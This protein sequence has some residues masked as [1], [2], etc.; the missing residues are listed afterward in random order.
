[1]QSRLS[2]IEQVAVSIVRY[3]A[4]RKAK[5][6]STYPSISRD[7]IVIEEFLEQWFPKAFDAYE[8][9]WTKKMLAILNE[10]L[11]DLFLVGD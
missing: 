8:G 10:W 6:M 2:E 1:M 4:F 7:L 9:V 11:R 3:S 5:G